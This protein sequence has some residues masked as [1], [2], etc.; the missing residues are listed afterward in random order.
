MASSDFYLIKRDGSGSWYRC[1]KCGT[2]ERFVPERCP[3]CD[4]EGGI[5]IQQHPELE[6]VLQALSAGL[7][8]EV[9]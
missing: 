3:V 2:M 5:A 7:E 9:L 8:K 6:Q 4:G 1:K